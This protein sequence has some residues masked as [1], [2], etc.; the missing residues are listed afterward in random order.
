MNASM[1]DTHNLGKATRL[2]LT[3]PARLTQSKSLEADLRPARMDRR[4]IAETRKETFD[5]WHPISTEDR[6]QYEFERRKYA[7][8]LIDFDRKFA[9]LFSGKPRT[10]E[11]QDGVA[12]EQL[13]E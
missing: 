6:A 2:N 10:Q 5:T 3:R 4:I 8:D 13:L 1:N 11:N 9:A 7:Q 12:H